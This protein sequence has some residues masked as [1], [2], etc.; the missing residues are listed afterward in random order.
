MSN[1]EALK[2]TSGKK[3]F[4]RNISLF[5][6]IILRAEKSNARKRRSR[7]TKMGREGSGDAEDH[8]RKERRPGERI[9]SDGRRRDADHASHDVTR[10]VSCYLRAQHDCFPYA[11]LHSRSCWIFLI[12]VLPVIRSNV[13]PQFLHDELKTYTRFDLILMHLVTKAKTKMKIV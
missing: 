5:A 7:S 8:S 9:S 3:L 1:I 2:L 12:P 4:R 6:R 10:R 13:D 11:A